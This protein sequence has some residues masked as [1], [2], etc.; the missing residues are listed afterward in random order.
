MPAALPAATVVVVRLAAAATGLRDA[1]ERDNAAATHFASHITLEIAPATFE[2][3][4]ETN[5]IAVRA[6]LA[7]AGVI[8]IH[9]AV[10]EP[11]AGPLNGLVA[12]VDSRACLSA[13][14]TR[15]VARTIIPAA[16]AA[17]VSVRRDLNPDVGAEDLAHGNLN[18]GSAALSRCI[19]CSGWGEEGGRCQRNGGHSGY[20]DAVHHGSDVIPPLSNR[21]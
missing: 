17:T 16:T 13:V 11:V 15:V 3:R 10:A 12:L 21:G 14:L 4:F 9:I 19:G 6:D 18:F 2:L 1:F 8:D 20:H 7:H 5:E